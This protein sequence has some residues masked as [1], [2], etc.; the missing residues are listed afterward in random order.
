MDD[1]ILGQVSE[2]CYDGYLREKL[3]QQVNTSHW[4]KPKRWVGLYRACQ[5]RYFTAWRGEIFKFTREI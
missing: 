4:R 3:L 5:E 1:N 2:E